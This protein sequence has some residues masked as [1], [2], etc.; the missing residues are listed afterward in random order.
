MAEA[1]A[2]RG[3]AATGY[4]PLGSRGRP[5][6]MKGDD[7]PDLFADPTIVSIAQTHD[8]TPAQVLL[9]DDTGFEFADSLRYTGNNDNDS[10]NNG[11]QKGI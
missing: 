8:T 1:M 11:S 10:N 4:S 5:D 2:S 9:A 6:V 7:E 3:I